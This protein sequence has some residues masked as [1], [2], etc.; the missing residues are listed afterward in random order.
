[1]LVVCVAAKQL[2]R[3][4]IGALQPIKVLNVIFLHRISIGRAGFSR[5]SPQKKFLW[6]RNEIRT[7]YN[8]W[9]IT[10]R[11]AVSS[12]FHTRCEVRRAAQHPGT[13]AVRRVMRGLA[14][15]SIFIEIFFEKDGFS[16]QA[17]Q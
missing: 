16:G 4:E 14:H 13:T 1:M 3:A 17:R 12:K 15:P 8:F 6:S 5:V 10:F 7:P 11:N 2:P 9:S